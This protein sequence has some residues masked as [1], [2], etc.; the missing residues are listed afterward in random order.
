MNSTRC[1]G[2]PHELKLQ[3]LGDWNDHCV[4]TLPAA[5]P[6]MIYGYEAQASV[7]LKHRAPQVI[8]TCSR[9]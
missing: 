2:S 1:T 6:N 4:S 7:F 9:D 8:L 3:S 5:H